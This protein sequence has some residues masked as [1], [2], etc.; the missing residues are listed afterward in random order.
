[1]DKLFYANIEALGK[2]FESQFTGKIIFDVIID[3]SEKHFK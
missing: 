2:G 3:Q 1:M